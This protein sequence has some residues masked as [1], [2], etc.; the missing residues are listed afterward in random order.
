MVVFASDQD[1]TSSSNHGK[2]Q[3][4]AEQPLVAS[5]AKKAGK[6]QKLISIEDMFKTERTLQAEVLQCQRSFTKLIQ[7]AEFINDAFQEWVSSWLSGGPDFDA[8]QKYVYLAPEGI[9]D[10]SKE[11][12]HNLSCKPSNPANT[13]YCDNSI[14][15]MRIRGP[16]K[17]VDRAIAKV[18]VPFCNSS[19]I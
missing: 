5:D 14:K 13:A 1:Q 4:E 3:R 9:D 12:F 17:H 8:V 7:D 15:G 11:C 18:S 16:L 2:N 19:L 6:V 10:Q